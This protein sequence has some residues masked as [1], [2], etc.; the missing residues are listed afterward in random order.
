MT[1]PT[2]Q[3]N[4]LLLVTNFPQVFLPSMKPNCIRRG[5]FTLIELLVSIGIVILLASL[6]ASGIRSATAR[7]QSASCLSQL[8]QIGSAFLSY[9]GENNQIGP[10]DAR[11][12]GNQTISLWRYNGKSVI[13]GP[14]M[15]YL[16][17]GDRST[18]PSLFI[19][20]GLPEAFVRVSPVR[21]TTR[22]IG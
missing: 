2:A 6:A 16:E 7:A 19:C 12:I 14:L 21:V 15:P 10:Y 20:P 18:T 13:F 4:R 5:A 11:D 8:R 22:R 1:S 17:T 9:A 3:R